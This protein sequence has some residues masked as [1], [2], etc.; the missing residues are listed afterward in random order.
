MI[1]TT[2]VHILIFALNVFIFELIYIIKVLDKKNYISNNNF[3]TKYKHKENVIKCLMLERHNCFNYLQVMYGSLQLKRYD[4]LDN[5]IIKILEEI[6]NTN[7]LYR[8]KNQQLLDTL[9]KSIKKAKKNNVNMTIEIK[10]SFCFKKGIP[11][12]QKAK[13]A[14]CLKLFQ[15]IIIN[16][17]KDLDSKYKVIKVRIGNDQKNN[18]YALILYPAVIYDDIIE[19]LKIKHNIYDNCYSN[20]IRFRISKSRILILLETVKYVES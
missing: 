9:F 17:L 4:K 18:V 15:S 2:V 16:K 11:F 3:I 10:D 14:E 1:S 8:I 19:A 7:P 20:S 5:Y 6:E 13:F 12:E